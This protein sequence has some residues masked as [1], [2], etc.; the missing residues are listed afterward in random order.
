MIATASHDKRTFS[1]TT[2]YDLP[3]SIGLTISIGFLQ[4]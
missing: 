2:E 4:F 1:D 3:V